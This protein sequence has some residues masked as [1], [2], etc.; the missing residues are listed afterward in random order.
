[1]PHVGRRS[2]RYVRLPTRESIR[3]RV[4]RDVRYA[5][6]REPTGDCRTNRARRPSL[7]L[8]MNARVLT[9]LRPT[10]HHSEILNRPRAILRVLL[11]RHM[12]RK[13]LISLRPSRSTEATENPTRLEIGTCHSMT[14]LTR[15]SCLLVRLARAA[16]SVTM[17]WP[18]SAST[19]ACR[20]MKRLN[21]VLREIQYC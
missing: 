6:W 5:T 15:G 13:A 18:S 20:S 3:C 21:S 14:S 19:A 10:P 12:C 1:M 16:N 4:L 11:S 2:E 9:S 8:H 17:P 7:S